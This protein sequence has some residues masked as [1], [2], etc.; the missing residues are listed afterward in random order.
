M[1]LPPQPPKNDKL[2][3]ARQALQIELQD[4]IGR[5]AT[6]IC[7]LTNTPG[8]I[9]LQEAGRLAGSTMFNV[10]ASVLEDREKLGFKTDDDLIKWLFDLASNQTMYAFIACVEGDALTIKEEPKEQEKKMH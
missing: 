4:V 7:E 9:L 5:H 8:N 6:L 1:Q 2:E 3:A 10:F